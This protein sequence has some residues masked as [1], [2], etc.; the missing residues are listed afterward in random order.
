MKYSVRRV[1][2]WLK[3]AGVRKT[4]NMLIVEMER[5]LRRTHLLGKPYYYF[6]DPCNYCNL[7][8]PLCAN[9]RWEPPTS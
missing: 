2:Y 3:F 1:A 9:R 6:I 7:H 4:T 8:C 5:V